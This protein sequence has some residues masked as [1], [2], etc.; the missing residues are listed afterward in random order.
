MSEASSE[1]VQNNRGPIWEFVTANRVKVLQKTRILVIKRRNRQLRKYKK[2][3]IC[4]IL[5][6][7][8]EPKY[9]RQMKARSI[10]ILAKLPSTIGPLHRDLIKKGQV[11]CQKK[12]KCR[13]CPKQE[14]REFLDFMSQSDLDSEDENSSECQVFG[15]DWWHEDAPDELLKLNQ[16]TSE[17]V[18]KPF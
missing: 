9:L 15:E 2:S 4:Q 12:F 13:P 5:T 14:R 16:L 11:A 3:V 6:L 1:F 17:G 8:N 10:M 7:R 18:L